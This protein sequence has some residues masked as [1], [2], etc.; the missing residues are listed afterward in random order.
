[1]SKRKINLKNE[2]FICLVQITSLWLFLFAVDGDFE[3]HGIWGGILAI[4]SL[5]IC[6]I[7][8]RRSKLGLTIE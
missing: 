5:A 6:M 4:V 2:V 8:G 7:A 1:M 3:A